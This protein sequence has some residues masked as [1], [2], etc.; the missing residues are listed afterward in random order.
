M[1]VMMPVTSWEYG[2]QRTYERL[3]PVRTY[4][5]L[6]ADELQIPASRL[7]GHVLYRY[8]GA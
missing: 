1:V 6:D 5:E 7:K 8:L 4:E 2:V 3:P